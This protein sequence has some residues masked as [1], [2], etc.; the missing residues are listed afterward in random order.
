[1]LVDGPEADRWSWLLAIGAA[2][3][4][5]A[6]IGGRQASRPC[7]ARWSVD[8]RRPRHAVRRARRSGRRSSPTPASR[9]CARLARPAGEPELWCRADG[10]PHGFLSTAAHAHAD[11]LSIEVRHGGVEILADPGTYCYHGEPEW[12]SYFRSTIAH[13]TI[14]LGGRDQSRSGG[15]FLWVRHARDRVVDVVAG[16]D[17]EI[18]SWTA[19]HDGYA[20]L[21]P[22][23]THRRTVR[24]DRG[25]VAVSTSST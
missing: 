12:R 11:A 6:C 10:G 4:R 18:E 24:L 25:A 17:G 21:D 8:A 9:C 3:V 1:M 15:P 14:E 19:E 2:R 16:A 13:N 7:S 22:P 23:A 5:P 20:G